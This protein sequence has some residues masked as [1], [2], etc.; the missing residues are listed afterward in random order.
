MRLRF[1]INHKGGPEP[2]VLRRD[3]GSPAVETAGRL[4]YSI[5]AAATLA[6]AV[7][8]ACVPAPPSSEA[9]TPPLGFATSATPVVAADAGGRGGIVAVAEPNAAAAGAR[10]LAAGGNAVDAA[11]AIQFA[12]N[13]TEP[14][15][16]GIGG[17]G[18]ALVYLAA[19]GRTAAL[20]FR[21][22]APQ[23]ATSESLPSERSY[24][25]AS[26]SGRAVG[27]PGTVDGIAKA[28]A[29]WGTMPLART[30][31]PAIALAE[32]GFAI[33]PAL[34]RA[35]AKGLGDGGRLVNESGNPAYDEARRVFAPD[36][37]APAAGAWLR[38][39]ELARALRLIAEYG[40]GAVYDCASPAGIAEAIVEA[41]R[42][43][44]AG[45][46]NGRGAMSC[47]D[48]AAYEA[49]VREPVIGGY[50]GFV[51]ASVPPPSSGGI[52]L[53]QMLAMLERFPIGETAR[54]GGEFGFGGYATLNVMQEVM[55]LAF[56][57][58]AAYIG[59]PAFTAVPVAGLLAPSYLAGRAAT[60]PDTDPD[61]ARY[62]VAVG[63]RLAGIGAGNPG[64]ATSTSHF[65]VADRF[66][67]LVAW[68]GTIE[69][70]W[71]TGLMVPGFG[72]LL[73]NELTDF[74]NDGRR[75]AG[76]ASAAE[77]AANA[78]APGKRPR[79][80]I[81][82]TIAFAASPS[83]LRPIAALG[84]PGGATIPN[85]VLAV[86]LNLID[87]GMPVQRAIDAPRLSLTTP[88]DGAVT[89]IEPGFDP[90]VIARLRATCSRPTAAEAPPACY[91][92]RET[93]AI[94]AVQAVVIDPASGRQ[95]GGADRRRD[96]TV[97]AV[98]SAAAVAAAP[99]T[100]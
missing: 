90:D 84:S 11:A 95:S 92:F 58:R 89:A 28:L 6:A 4:M 52:T 91:Q 13:V 46:P 63:K 47:A 81:T 18:F 9:A 24:A 33:G 32:D 2:E 3:P 65:S 23:A 99:P 78:I 17:G 66:G 94:G 39:P 8:A 7:L 12:L 29:L 79:S 85:S 48:L 57:D 50:R 87:F 56:A 76:E 19:T 96:G 68:T 31:E 60:C 1:R 49:L 27:V 61:D 71:G 51:V 35:L 93:D 16:S 98:P 14:Q 42:A 88:A 62:C 25:V 20:D 44:R 54:A 5:V 72:F 67:N 64:A 30:L 82:P 59:D 75:P 15:S 34:A 77:S 36:G 83:G 55:R 74:D 41:Q 22:T 21:E 43:A 53:L 100:R 97:I 73:N 45:D 86:L 70:A 10:I 38:Q 69:N 26:T 37:G 80:S 40:S